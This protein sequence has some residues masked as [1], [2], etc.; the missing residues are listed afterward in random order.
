MVQPVR[1]ERRCVICNLQIRLKRPARASRAVNAGSALGVL[2]AACGPRGS[3]KALARSLA[4]R[5]YMSLSLSLHCSTHCLQHPRTVIPSSPVFVR[6][7]WLER[8]GDA[9]PAMHLARG[10]GFVCNICY[11][12]EVAGHRLER[13][14]DDRG[15]S[16][17][18]QATPVPAPRERGTR[19]GACRCCYYSSSAGTG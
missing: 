10:G 1:V 8:A 13:R 15:D 6:G 9:V 5:V 18:R 12:R 17:R 3:G 2:P 7:A 14:S 11:R 4:M 16:A 19:T